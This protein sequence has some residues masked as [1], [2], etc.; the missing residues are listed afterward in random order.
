MGGSARLHDGPGADRGAACG[1]FRQGG[2]GG[3]P[4]VRA[5][6]RH[7][8]G[9]VA[10]AAMPVGHCFGDEASVSFAAQP[11][12]V[13]DCAPVAAI[14]STL[15]MVPSWHELGLRWSRLCRAPHRR[16]HFR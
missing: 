3:A 7:A 15:C 16:D 5:C 13:G 6:G 10:V 2:A 11:V 1:T 4:F 9:A 8:E 14:R 12:V